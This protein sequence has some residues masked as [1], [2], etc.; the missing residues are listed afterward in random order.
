M[1]EAL[2]LPGA[3]VDAA[4]VA[5]VL[6]SVSNPV[7]AVAELRRVLRPG[8]TLHVLEHVS[9]PAGTATHRRQHRYGAR[10]SRLAGGCS[11]TRDT[12][13]LLAEGG[14][15]TADLQDRTARP[16][17]PLVGPHVLGTLPVAR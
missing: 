13:R 10:W 4:L 8:G 2:P 5:L 17:P 14:F 9:A 15:D 1:A 16:T 11:V 3:S 12:R 7:A 6:C